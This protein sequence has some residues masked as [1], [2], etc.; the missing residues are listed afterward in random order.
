MNLNSKNILTNFLS[1]YN[2]SDENLEKLK[3]A[4]LDMLNDINECAKRHNIKYHLAYGTL[5]GA[6][7]HKGYIPWDDDIDLAVNY[8]DIPKLIEALKE[9][10][11]DK[12]YF[13][14][15]LYPYL[16]R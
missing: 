10:Y 13:G 7:R 16:V 8:P 4:E 1:K 2:L 3:E 9:D 6:I 15:F 5:L 11:K 12:Y 14:G